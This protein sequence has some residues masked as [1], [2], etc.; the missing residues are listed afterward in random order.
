MEK[1]LPK[2]DDGDIAFGGYDDEMREDIRDLESDSGEEGNEIHGDE[3]GGD[4][5]GGEENGGE[6][7]GG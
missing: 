1:L 4:R 7:N 3:N 6:Q 5:N 2:L